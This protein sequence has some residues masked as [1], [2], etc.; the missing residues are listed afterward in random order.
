MAQ[1]WKPDP[2]FKSQF[3]L[4]PYTTSGSLYAS[5]FP[6][7]KWA[8]GGPLT[9]LMWHRVSASEVLGPAFYSV[10][11]GADPVAGR[12]LPELD[13]PNPSLAKGKNGGRWGAKAGYETL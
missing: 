9:G 6:S 3:P 13:F 4:S 12:L 5:I 2:G 10:E 11:E 8:G 1:A 7:L